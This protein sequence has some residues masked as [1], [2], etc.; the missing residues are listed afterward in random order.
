MFLAP[1]WDIFHEGIKRWT[2]LPKHCAV[3]FFLLNNQ[4]IYD[5]KKDDFIQR[6]KDEQYPTEEE[7]EEELIKLSSFSFPNTIGNYPIEI[8]VSRR[9]CLQ[10]NWDAILIKLL[11]VVL[12][13][14]QIQIWQNTV[15]YPLILI[16]FRIS[17]AEIT[18]IIN[19]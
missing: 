19:W 18:I 7:E 6:F 13:A 15:I 17:W 3:N 1:S 16:W 9:S 2:G 4:T 12:N 10:K 14:I 5:P 11:H 8:E